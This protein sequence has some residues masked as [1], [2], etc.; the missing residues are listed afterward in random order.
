MFDEM[1]AKFAGS[2]RLK[3]RRSPE[4]DNAL[5]IFGRQGQIYEYDSERLGVMFMPPP[6]NEDKWGKWCPKRWGNFRRTGEALGMIVT[7]NGDSEGCMAFDP[8]NKA[9]VKLAIKIAGAR[10]KRQMSPEGLAKLAIAR[11][12]LQ[13]P[14]LEGP[15]VS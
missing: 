7:Q 3:V 11:Q 15:L 12:K 2:H 13:K 1:I 9:Q 8:A 6:T 4:D 10:S 5:I 14:L